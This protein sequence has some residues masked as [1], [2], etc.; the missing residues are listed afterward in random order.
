M[1]LKKLAKSLAIATTL[2]VSA[3]S[4]S[5]ANAGVSF[6]KSV[7]Q[8]LDYGL[9]WF[10]YNAAQK[11]VPGVANHYYQPHKKTVIF[12]HGWQKNTVKKQKRSTLDRGTGEDLSQY[13]LDRGYNVGILYWNQFADESEVKDA[14]AKIYSTN[15]RRNMRWLDV[16]GNYRGG[17]NKSVTDLLFE[18]VNQNMGNFTGS[19][20]RLVGHSL[21][22]QVAI[23]LGDRLNTAVN[24]GA[25]PSSLRPD[26]IALLDP[27]YSK[28]GKSYLGGQWTGAVARQSANRLIADGTVFEAYRSSPVTSTFLVGDAN[29]GLL[30]KTAFTEARPWYYNWFQVD[31]KHQAPVMTYFW[32]IAYGAPDLKNDSQPAA[33]ASTSDARIKTLMN[34]SFSMDQIEGRYSKTPADDEFKK[35]SR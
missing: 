29:T 3:L 4:S 5:V 8:N 24:S 1:T 19:H 23:A 6:P 18:A 9:Y 31:K 30:D 7:F 14:E 12:I 33:S 22:N 20:F 26:R 32:S 27:F 13:W 15:G 25:L 11:A 10:G 2:G 21:G 35:V 34:A 16:N 17:P 28:D